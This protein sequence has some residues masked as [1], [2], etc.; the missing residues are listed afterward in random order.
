MIQRS[1]NINPVE[2]DEVESRQSASKQVC[3]IRD[4][5]FEAAHCLPNVPAGHKCARLHGHSF[6][7]ELRCEGEIDPHTGWLID[8]S[9]IK[10]VFDPILNQLDHHYLNEIEGLSDTDTPS[11]AKWISKQ[12]EEILPQLDR[13]DLYETPGCGTTLCWGKR[14]P[15]LPV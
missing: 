1:E 6:R 3:L 9:D 12:M 10:R 13:I 2:C 7:I 15:A 4:F 8:F 14:S 5:T 11:L